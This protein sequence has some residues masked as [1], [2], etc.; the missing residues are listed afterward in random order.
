MDK[1]L[2]VQAYLNGDDLP[3][4]MSID[5]FENNP[6]LMFLAI[7]ISGDKKLYDFCSDT[8]KKDYTFV[9]MLIRKF[10]DDKEFVEQVGDYY[11]A[12]YRQEEPDDKIRILL[13]LIRTLER[14][15]NEIEL[16]KYRVPLAAAYHTDMISIADVIE[17]EPDKFGLGFNIMEETY[18]HDTDILDYYANQMVTSVF[19][20]NITRLE[21]TLHKC[22]YKTETV[23]NTS[24]IT[25]IV[26]HVKNYD[27]ALA[28]YIALHPDVFKELAKSFLAVKDNWLTYN[29]M[30]LFLKVNGFIDYVEPNEEWEFEDIATLVYIAAKYNVKEYFFNYGENDVSELFERYDEYISFSY[31]NL[32]E[33]NIFEQIDA[34]FTSFRDKK[35]LLESEKVFNTIWNTRT[36]PEAREVVTEYIDSYLSDSKEGQII[37]FPPK[38]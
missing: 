19:P 4:N 7:L 20:L 38:K 25:F 35:Y 6:E 15:G 29:D 8:V 14:K 11:L 1:N 3:N 36:I 34:L 31:P 21:D 27:K 17:Q 16:I 5:E 13:L 23:L 22:N 37:T 33:K 30:I 32:K 2:I 10:S 12:N 28:A 18:D 24:P 9:N 26:N